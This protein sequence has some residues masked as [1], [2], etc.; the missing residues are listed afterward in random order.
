MRFPVDYTSDVW[1]VPDPLRTHVAYHITHNHA[2]WSPVPAMINAIEFQVDGFWNA[3]DYA[4]IVATAPM[5][6]QIKALQ[7][8][9]VHQSPTRHYQRDH[10]HQQA[11]D[12]YNIYRALAAYVARAQVSGGSSDML[13]LLYALSGE[14]KRVIAEL[15]EHDTRGT[16]TTPP[17]D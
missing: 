17:N 13:T 1:A 9:P 6:K 2:I 3:T 11:T 14:L 8:K 4:T 12:L 7:D 10:P 15:A 16:H 5:I